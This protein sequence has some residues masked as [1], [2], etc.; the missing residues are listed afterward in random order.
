MGIYFGIE[1]VSLNPLSELKTPFNSNKST[2]GCLDGDR[3]DDLLDQYLESSEFLGASLGVYKDGCSDYLAAGG[4]SNKRQRSSMVASTQVRTA[5]VTK[6]MTAIAIMQLFEKGILELDT[7][8]GNYLSN[9]PNTLIRDVTVR[10]LLGHTSGV[11][12]YASVFE[13]MSYSQ[14]EALSESLRQFIDDPLDSPPGTEYQYTSYGYSILGAII[15]EQTGK[16]YRE[17]MRDHIWSVAG[18]SNTQLDGYEAHGNVGSY[19][20]LGSLFIRLPRTD[21]SIIYPAGGVKSTVEDLLKFGRAVL[22]N[23]LIRADTFELMLNVEDSLSV[24]AGDSPYGLGWTVL[25]SKSFG[26]FIVHSGSQ[27]GAESFF[28]I[29][30]DQPAVVA[31]LA[32]AYS[33]GNEAY[34]LSRDVAKATLTANQ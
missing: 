10:Q 2:V 33:S 21:L 4:W 32:N 18:M 15:E 27:P 14:Y 23:K 20:K 3:L 11:R 25:E 28:A 19:L 22:G 17:Y 1:P 13:A 26:K 8:I 31:V 5:S 6:P 29:Y 9:L 16:S 34:L 7:P 12:G 30:L 24:K